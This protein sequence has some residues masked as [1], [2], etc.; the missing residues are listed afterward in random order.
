M[1][2]KPQKVK[3][4]SVYGKKNLTE[5]ISYLLRCDNQSVHKTLGHTSYVNKS[6]VNGR[7]FPVSPKLSSFPGKN[8]SFCFLLATCHGQ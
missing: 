7:R 4:R 2:L 1:P 5:L 8:L 3:M 6:T